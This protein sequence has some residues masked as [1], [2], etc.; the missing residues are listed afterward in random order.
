MKVQIRPPKGVIGAGMSLGHRRLQAE[1][2][3]SSRPG[4]HDGREGWA[5]TAPPG[6]AHAAQEAGGRG[7]TGGLSGARAQRECDVP[8][9]LEVRRRARQMQ[10]HA[11]DRADDVDPQLQQP[12]A[13]PRHLAAAHA[14]RAA[15]NRSSCMST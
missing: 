14:V 3:L 5:A 7:A 1:P 11:A 2:G 12:V 15:R 13:Q 10:N 8:P 9:R 4:G 6:A